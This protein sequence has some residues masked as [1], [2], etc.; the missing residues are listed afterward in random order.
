MGLKGGITC[1]NTG[2]AYASADGPVVYFCIQWDKRQRRIK[3]SY[4][5]NRRG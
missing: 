2:A 4:S 5:I 1:K 3:G